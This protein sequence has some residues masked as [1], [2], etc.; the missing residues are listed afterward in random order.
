MKNK[1][2]D[3]ILDK[4]AAGIR[5][6]QVDAAVANDATE[7]VWAQLSVE[8]DARK[9]RAHRPPDHPSAAAAPR[10]PV[11]ASAPANTIEGCADF[12][13]LIPAYLGGKLSEARS[14]LLVD[15]THECIPCRRALKQARESR[16]AAPTPARKQARKTFN[17]SLSPV[18]VRWGI[19]AMLVIGLGLIALPLIQRYLPLGSFE[20]T[21]EAADGSVYSVADSQTRAIS[22]GEKLSRN[23]VIRTAK[24]AHAVVRLGDGSTIEMKD[25]SEFSIDQTLRGTTIHLDRGSVIVEAAKQKNHLFVDTG[26]SLVSVTGTTFSANAGTKGSRVSVIEGEVRLDRAGQQRVLRAGEQ[27]T[28]SAS[29]E[30]IPIKDEVSWSRNAARYAQTLESLAAL[31]TELNSVAKPGVR[32]STRLL[33][34]MPENTALYAALPNLGAT[35][36]ESHRIMQE[37]I[38]QNPALREWF[39]NSRGPKGPAVDQAIS[40]IKEFG[41]QLG[42]EIAVSAGMDD[43]GNPVGPIV[44]AELKNPAG[45]H[46]FF[47]S[48]IQKMAGGGKGPQVQWVDDPRTAQPSANSSSTATKDKELYV[49]INGDVLVASP[50]LDQ[51]QSLARNG[52]SAS[53]FSSTP[54]YARVADVY[55]E[56]AGLVVAADL[57]KIISHTRGLRRIAVGDQHEQ[58]LNQLGVFNLK[59]FVLDQKDTDGKTHTRAVLSFNQAD[60]G[61]TT[62]LAPPAPM[63]S[64]EYISPDANLVA[65]FVVKN[66]TALVDDLLGALDT[67]CPDLKKHLNQLQT[68]HGLDLRKDF[69]A[70]LGGEYAFAIDGPIL[71]TP[72]WK[73]IFEVNDPAHLQQTFERVVEEINKQVATKEGGKGLA[74]E[75]SDS[76]GLTFY[77]LRSKDFGME[78]NYTFNKGYMIVGPSRALIEQAL[79]YHDTGTTL[80][81]SAKFTAGLPADGNA[82]FS[83]LVYHNLAPLVQPFANQIG[84]S[85][86][87]L[88]DEQRKTITAM[89]ANMQPTLAYA[90]AYGDR[91]EFASNT[92]GGPFGLSPATLLGMPNAF[93]LEHI[94][95]QGMRKK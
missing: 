85:T 28:T 89:A 45:F 74:L 70:P 31:Q 32:H 71:P 64:L 54:F 14:L 12:Q 79:Q 56:G 9:L 59:S 90:Y 44:L 5:N 63:G 23:Q 41:E 6:E 7:R 43:Q 16:V 73:L 68:D 10:A 8:A 46:A 18:V 69:A 20:A 33:D 34:M 61:I 95:G 82:N 66:P 37:R 87:S 55:R 47:D 26:D 17:Y 77:T 52:Q 30:T 36:A 3:N 50:K 81:R 22:A 1:E 92:E 88:P 29:I 80:N 51:L 94:L 91:I 15:H 84:N 48:E 53:G 67:V 39:Q 78:V 11:D 62:W 13:S 2:L 65:G 72:S 24:D 57:E 19:A 25:R 4:V 60:H 93:E 40:V 35:I 38:Q 75:H 42:D 86:K 21:V 83:A 58:A 27:A 49:W 76:G